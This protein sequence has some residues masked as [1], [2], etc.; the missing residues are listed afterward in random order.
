MKIVLR[1]FGILHALG[2][3]PEAFWNALRKEP[4]L[5]RTAYAQLGP[6]QPEMQI[7]EDRLRRM[8]RFSQ[9]LTVA[10]K[11]ALAGS[12]STV[13]SDRFGMITSTQFGPFESIIN[14]ST[15]IYQAGPNRANPMEFPNT[16]I[17]AAT[18]HACIET[19]LS[20]H[21]DTLAGP[22]ALA[23]AYDAL[24]L[25]RADRMVAAGVDELGFGQRQAL[26]ALETGENALPKIAGQ[27]RWYG[28]GAAALVLEKGAEHLGPNQVELS[29][30]I[31]GFEAETA[32]GVGAQTGSIPRQLQAFLAKSG[33]GPAAL[34]GVIFS[35]EGGLASE[36]RFLKVVQEAFGSER[37]D[38]PI[39]CLAQK[40][41]YL[42]GAAEI[43]AALCARQILLSGLWPQSTFKRVDPH[44]SIGARLGTPSV[45]L[46]LHWDPFGA[47]F[48]YL[49]S[50]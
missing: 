15:R 11:Q 34:G 8:D 2:Q 43:V 3:N 6:F 35:G 20:G 45:I 32:F 9:M 18:G 46:V 36:G 4:A 1:N 22:G 50:R 49:F 5:P 14:F 31:S 7:N 29:G 40:T 10:V 39:F 26:N 27:D 19:G 44:T 21:N 12:D 16:V 41:G 25:G 47:Y 17:N 23:A 38:L 30:Y 48:A 33:V 13:D 42:W 28:E 24:A 37:P